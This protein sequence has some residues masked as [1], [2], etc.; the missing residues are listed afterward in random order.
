MKIRMKADVSGSRNGQPWPARGETLELPDDEAANLCANGMA[1]PVGDVDHDVERAIPAPAHERQV[2][3]GP[4]GDAALP[5]D[6]GRDLVV[7]GQ[8]D[9]AVLSASP[10]NTDVAA[11][12]ADGTEVHPDADRAEAEKS[13]DQKSAAEPKPRRS[14]RAKPQGDSKT[15]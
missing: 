6:A 4:V 9:K 3:D 13:A 1:E 10:E 12:T 2:T 11:R 15:S 14:T 5:D 8:K 7:Q